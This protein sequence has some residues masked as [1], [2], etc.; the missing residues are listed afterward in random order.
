MSRFEV[1]GRDRIHTGLDGGVE[2]LS[3]SK[4]ASISRN[5]PRQTEVLVLGARR[6]KALTA[7][8]V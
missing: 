6:W 2:S 1:T 5:S 8:W 3:S 4:G 7:Q